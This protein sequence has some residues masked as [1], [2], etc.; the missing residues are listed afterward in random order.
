MGKRCWT[1]KTWCWNG[2]EVNL[3][4]CTKLRW[5]WGGKVTSRFFKCCFTVIYCF[6]IGARHK[7]TGA[8]LIKKARIIQSITNEPFLFFNAPLPFIT[9]FL[10]AVY[11]LPAALHHLLSLELLYERPLERNWPSSLPVSAGYSLIK[12]A[13]SPLW[14]QWPAITIGSGLAC[15]KIFIDAPHG[16]WE[17]CTNMLT[18]SQTFLRAGN[19][20]WII[21]SEST[22]KHIF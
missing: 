8:A 18:S 3:L 17:L 15:C 6:L 14:P 11:L 4:L 22:S 13:L 9:H 2:S 19:S 10:P 7:S 1:I 20:I 12:P 5:K 21:A 16:P